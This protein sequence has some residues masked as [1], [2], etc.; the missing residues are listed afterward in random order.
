M[1]R[2]RKKKKL[3]GVYAADN[4]S[5]LFTKWKII[6]NPLKIKMMTTEQLTAV[7]F[8]KKQAEAIENVCSKCGLWDTD[9]S[10]FFGTP[11]VEVEKKQNSVYFLN[12]DIK[13]LAQANVDVSIRVSIITGNLTFRFFKTIR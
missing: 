8:T 5:R 9:I 3:W 13:Q 7:G 2:K 11:Y 10:V 1:F 6:T 12:L 4:L